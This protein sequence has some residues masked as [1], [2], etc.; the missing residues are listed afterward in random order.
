M[1]VLIDSMAIRLRRPIR[2]RARSPR[3]HIRQ[4]VVRSTPSMRAASHCETNKI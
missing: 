2:T 4:I 3:Q 1:K